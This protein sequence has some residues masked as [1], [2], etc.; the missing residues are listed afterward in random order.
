AFDEP[1][2]AARTVVGSCSGAPVTFALP[3]ATDSCS[4]AT[5]SCAPLPGDRFGAN[6]VACTASDASGHASVAT[7]TVN[8]LQPLTVRFRSPLSADAINRFTVGQTI[9]YEIKLFDCGNSDVTNQVAVTVKLAV[10]PVP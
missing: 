9:P 1:S 4:T 6:S 3:A 10:T 8:V 2:L 5:V 7:L